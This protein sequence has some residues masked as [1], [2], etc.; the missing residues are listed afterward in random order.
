MVAVLLCA[1]GVTSKPNKT[2]NDKNCHPPKQAAAAAAVKHQDSADTPQEAN[3]NP[4]KWYAAFKGPEW[5]L[6]IAAFG[7]LG[8]VAWQAVETRRATQAAQRSINAVEGENRPWLLVEFG[9][10]AGDSIT[11][12][13]PINSTPT[14]SFRIKN[15]GRTPAELL[16]IK[17]DLVISDNPKTPPSKD[18]VEDG[19]RF[20]P[21]I[22]PQKGVL[23]QTTELLA[24]IWDYNAA[25]SGTKNYLW[26]RGIVEYKHTIKSAG[27]P[28]YQTKFSY[29]WESKSSYWR[30]VQSR[31]T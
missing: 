4:P 3:D 30:L 13:N 19:K 28:N 26:L 27:V 6:V 25:V 7:T 14:C 21:Q 10:S 8:V 2:A 5:W 16:K 18:I 22:L 11:S 12:P 1:I 17:A 20:N 29:L 9:E 23:V 15:Y 31:V 24:S